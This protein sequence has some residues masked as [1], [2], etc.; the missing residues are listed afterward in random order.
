VS[1]SAIIETAV[2]SFLL[3][4]GADR[5][6]AA[7]TRRFDRLIR[8][9]QRLGRNTSVTM[10]MLAVFVRFLLTY[11]AA[12]RPVPGDTILF[13]AVCTRQPS[14]AVFL[15]DLIRLV[16]FLIDPVECNGGVIDLNLKPTLYRSRAVWRPPSAA[17][18]GDRPDLTASNWPTPHLPTS[19][20]RNQVGR[21]FFDV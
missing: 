10:E 15:V 4:D 6:K 13:A 3:P 7:F 18:S 11:A 5:R 9:I 19:R 14:E 21:R 1:Q 12:A 2:M 16:L 8:Q 17:D 20:S